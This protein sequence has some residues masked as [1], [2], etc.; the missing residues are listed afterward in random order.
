MK[1]ITKQY[2]HGTFVES[3]GRALM[4]TTR[5]TDGRTIACVTLGD[6]EDTR[7]VVAAAKGAF[8]ASC[9][10]RKIAVRSCRVGRPR[11]V[12]CMNAKDPKPSREL[13]SRA[14]L[15]PFFDDLNKSAATMQILHR[16]FANHALSAYDDQALLARCWCVHRSRAFSAAAAPTPRFPRNEP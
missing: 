13:H 12:V 8:P 11:L 16:N 15:A 10:R 9:S 1:T 6:Q 4:D 7:R 2:I 14:A 3:H 5:W